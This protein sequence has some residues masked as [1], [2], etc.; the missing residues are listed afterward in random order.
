MTLSIESYIITLPSGNVFCVI[1]NNLKTAIED[2][3]FAEEAGLELIVGA[4][5]T[6]SF[7]ESYE[8]N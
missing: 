4:R 6:V 2:A 3:Q 7:L 8:L 1:A 5:S